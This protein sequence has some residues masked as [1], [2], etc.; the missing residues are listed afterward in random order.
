M[1]RRLEL[2]NEMAAAQ[3]AY[4]AAANLVRQ[5]LDAREEGGPEAPTDLD[6]NEALREHHEALMRYEDL[7]EEYFRVCEEDER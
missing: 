7:R 4:I 5:L 6:L 2:A 3:A 1:S